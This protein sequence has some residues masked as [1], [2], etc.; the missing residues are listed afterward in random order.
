[1][2]LM[3]LVVAASTAV[4]LVQP[5]SAQHTFEDIPVFTT[6]VSGH[7]RAFRSHRPIRDFVIGTAEV[8]D[9]TVMTDRRFTITAKK[10]GITSVM[11]LH[12][13]D[14]DPTHMEIQVVTALQ[15]QKSAVRVR[16]FAKGQT[17]T[18]MYWCDPDQGCNPDP[19]N[20]G[21]ALIESTTVLDIP[22]GGRAITTTT[23]PVPA[24]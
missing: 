11:V 19:E 16:S 18:S 15:H 5:A 17:A 4:L 21:I 8:A 1:M 24:R 23:S 9:V 12:E 20:K 2:K 22:G 10:N 3:G 7:V 14:S 13:D 6:M